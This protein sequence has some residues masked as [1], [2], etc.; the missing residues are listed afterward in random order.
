MQKIKTA[1]LMSFL[2]LGCQ[3]TSVREPSGF[4]SFFHDAVD[5][6]KL[7]NL[8]KSEHDLIHNAADTFF[9]QHLLPSGFNGGMLVSYK[10]NIV[11]ERYEGK[12]RYA[13]GKNMDTSSALHLAS[14]SKTF[15][16]MAVLS[17]W[18]AGKLNI[19]DQVSAY[20]TGF[21][22][23]DITIKNLLNHRS[24]L[25]NYVHFMEQ[26]GWDREKTVTNRDILEFMTAH[27]QELNVMRPDASFNYS[28]TNYALLALIIE[29]T[30]GMTYSQYLK[31]TFFKPLDMNDSYVFSMEKADYAIPSYDYKGRPE[32]MMYLDA[33][34]GDKNVYSTPRDLYKWDQA[35]TF[36]NFFKKST[37]DAAYSGYSH[38]K[39][40]VKNYGLGWR[41]NDYPGGKKV[42]YHN[43]WWHGNNAVFSRL[44]NDSA[45]IIVL[46]NKFTRKIYEARRLY[47]I[48]PGYDLA[49]DG[50]E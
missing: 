5:A 48:F 4:F 16:A 13:E 40:G 9:K 42:V 17:L 8:T 12:E 2:L 25:P 21:P 23:K 43:G 10:G 47:S 11:F 15:T 22:F 41:L 50:D 7:P 49:F 33:V 46:G 28:N 39:Q 35:L 3:S 36:G 1:A 20:L 18:E 30:S 26:L 27:Q 45:T 37:L 29:K 38:E 6:S 31:H 44:I 14:V 32:P 19:D 34:V 24:G